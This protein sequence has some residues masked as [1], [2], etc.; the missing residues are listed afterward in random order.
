MFQFNNNLHH[1]LIKFLFLS[2]QLTKVIRFHLINKRIYL[3]RITISF[4]YLHLDAKWK[5]VGITIAGE[6]DKGNQLNQLSKPESIC[7]HDDQTIYIADYG[8]H[9]II[10]WKSNATNV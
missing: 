2:H 8:N 6:N 10:E 4:F 5:Q 3:K 9:R 7:I 1:L